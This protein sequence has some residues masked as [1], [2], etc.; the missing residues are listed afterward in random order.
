[1]YKAIAYVIFGSGSPDHL[2]GVGHGVAMSRSPKKAVES[3]IA[4]A[5]RDAEAGAPGC[6]GWVPLLE[7]VKLWHGSELISCRV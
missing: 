4:H 3:A 1:M 6:V 7:E 2:Y 5:H